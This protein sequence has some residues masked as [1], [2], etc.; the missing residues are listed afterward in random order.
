MGEEGV[1]AIVFRSPCIAV[2]KASPAMEITEKCVK[3]ER[4]IS[5]LGCPA[6][7][8]E[9]GMIKIEKSLCFGCS[10]CAQICPAEAISVTGREM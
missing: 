4:C 6:I 7:V 2:A 8:R 9:N 1:K 5:E 3:C 10:L